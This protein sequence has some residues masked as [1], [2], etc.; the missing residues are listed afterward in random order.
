MILEHIQTSYNE[1]NQPYL[2]LLYMMMI[3]TAYHGLL[4]VG[5]ITTSPHTI[6]AR[7]IHTAHN[8]QKILIRLRMSKT[9][10]ASD[11]LQIV[12]F[13]PVKPGSYKT[14]P[15]FCPYNIMLKFL[16]MRGDFEDDDELLFIFRSGI[17]I[18]ADH[19]RRVLCRAIGTLGL[20]L[21]AY[22]AHS[23]RSGQAVD[24]E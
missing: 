15:N 7:D 16:D 3:L 18:K 21:H 8:N 20:N 4:R 1:R 5:E 24:M 19:F 9:H 17:G 23:L 2:V 13:G 14:T 22:N 6:K 10:C 11:R 12:K